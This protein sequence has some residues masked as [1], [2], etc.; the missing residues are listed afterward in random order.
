MK[1]NSFGVSKLTFRTQ[2]KIKNSPAK[3]R[4]T[5][6]ETEILSGT[7][8]EPVP[9][10]KDREGLPT[11]D[12]IL[13]SLTQIE[14]AESNSDGEDC[15]LHIYETRYDTRGQE[16]VLRAGTKSRFKEEAPKRK[17]HRACLVLNRYYHF[18]GDRL[19]YTELEIQSK[20]IIRAFRQVIG[21]Y[22]GLDL[23]SNLVIIK[24]PPRCIF[25]YRTDLQKYAE[26]SGNEFLKSHMDLCLQYADKILYREIKINNASL[27]ESSR[28][29]DLE[30]RHLWVVFRP[31]CLVYEKHGDIER[32][33]RLRSMR[34]GEHDDNGARPWILNTERVHYTG[35]VIGLTSHSIEISPYDG[36]KSVR[37]LNSVPLY[38]HPEERRI[39]RDL[40]E[41]GRKFLSLCGMR[42]CF[43]DGPAYMGVSTGDTSSH[44][45][46]RIFFC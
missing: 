35:S 22:D 16:V 4:S 25:H 9:K 32:V 20:H 13:S 12:E 28:T 36:F 5:E 1:S 19:A 8:T 34:G 38:L 10:P 40:L 41:R 43:Y 11:Q 30:H 3:T 7:N 33:S 44:V 46:V 29:P 39:R 2:R 26:K 15:E 27:L 17:S 24:E 45:N 21:S 31:G 42:H 14:E 37:E 6:L 18:P 23:E